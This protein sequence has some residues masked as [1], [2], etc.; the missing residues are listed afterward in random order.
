MVLYLKERKQISLHVAC[1]DIT[2]VVL[3]NG[4][5]IVYVYDGMMI[6]VLKEGKREIENAI[7]WQ[8]LELELVIAVKEHKDEKANQDIKRLKEVFEN[9][10]IIK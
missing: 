7:R 4:K 3:E 10:E 9:L 8:G 1:G 2:D 6:N 5:I